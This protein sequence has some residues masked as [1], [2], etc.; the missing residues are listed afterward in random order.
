MIGRLILMKLY[1]KIHSFF[2][3]L[4]RMIK[5]FKAEKVPKLL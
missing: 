2:I 4:I 1:I 3:T 5:I